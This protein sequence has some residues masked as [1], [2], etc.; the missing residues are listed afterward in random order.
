MRALLNVLLLTVQVRVY[1]VVR[2]RFSDCC[3]NHSFTC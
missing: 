1:A 3:S 2:D